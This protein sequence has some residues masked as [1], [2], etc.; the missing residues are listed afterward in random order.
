MPAGYQA[1]RAGY[2][3]LI[4]G[5]GIADIVGWR[6]C[7][8]VV[9]FRAL[10]DKQLSQLGLI[11][12]PVTASSYEDILQG[13]IHDVTNLHWVY[14]QRS[15]NNITPEI[16]KIVYSIVDFILAVNPERSPASLQRM[17]LRFNTYHPWLFNAF[18][19]RK[20]RRQDRAATGVGFRKSGSGMPIGSWPLIWLRPAPF[21]NRTCNCSARRNGS[22]GRTCT[23]YDLQGSEFISEN[24][25]GSFRLMYSLPDDTGVLLAEI[26]RKG[27]GRERLPGA[28]L[29]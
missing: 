28:D 20:R 23:R 9:F 21:P 3:P 1:V 24:S 13:S 6:C 5:G 15:Y 17:L 22:T 2:A 25:G 10:L 4:V 26:G 27:S 11:Q 14:L 7:E 16:Q 29:A 18:P 8:K 12:W 19:V